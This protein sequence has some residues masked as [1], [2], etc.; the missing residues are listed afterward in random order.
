MSRGEDLKILSVKIVFPDH[1]E[2]NWIK[3][4]ENKYAKQDNKRSHIR[5]KIITKSIKDAYSR[6]G[7]KCINITCVIGSSVN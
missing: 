7:N 2:S 5:K 4:C 3:F 1:V 6:I